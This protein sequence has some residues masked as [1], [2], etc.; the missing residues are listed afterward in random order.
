MLAAVMSRYCKNK[1]K[2]ADYGRVTDE[3]PVQDGKEFV[4]ILENNKAKKRRLNPKFPP[5]PPRLAKM[6]P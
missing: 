5:N 4:T 6:E 3:D 2:R 1:E